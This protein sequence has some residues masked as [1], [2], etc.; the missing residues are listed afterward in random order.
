MSDIWFAFDTH[1]GHSNPRTGIGIIQFCNRPFSSIEEMDAKMIE[2][3]NSVVS[4][5]DTVYVSDFAWRNHNHYIMAIKGKKILI[6]G[7]HDKISQDILKNFTEIH[8]I[9]GITIDGKYIVL[10]HYPM[11]SWNGKVYKSWHLHGH[12]HGRL[13]DEQFLAI[14]VGV[15]DWKYAPVNYDTIREILQKRQ[16]TS[17]DVDAECLQDE[18]EDLHEKY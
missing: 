6:R 10:C 4:S 11:R 13:D 1:F 12:C 5:K 18:T 9:K 7:N 16:D 14:D 2:N 15:D 3:W 17:R 8:D